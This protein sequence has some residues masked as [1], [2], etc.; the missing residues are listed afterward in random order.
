[1]CENVSRVCAAERR[2]RCSRSVHFSY[3]SR[4]CEAGAILRGGGWRKDFFHGEMCE[5]GTGP[6]DA[7]SEKWSIESPR[8]WMEDAKW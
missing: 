6:C 8:H 7:G 4:L 2:Y 5:M 1:M 3:R